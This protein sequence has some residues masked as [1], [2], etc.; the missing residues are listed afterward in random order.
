MAYIGEDEREAD[1][2][3]GVGEAVE[4]LIKLLKFA[5]LIN[6]PLQD[7]V[8]DTQEISLNGVRIMLGLGGKGEAASHELAE[9][10]AMHPMNVSRATAELRRE[11]RVEERCDPANRRRKPLH[12]TSAGWRSYERLI[13]QIRSVAEQLFA[14]V[15][16][17]EQR[18]LSCMID[19][20]NGEIEAT[21]H[22]AA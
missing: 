9:L 3:P 15:T 11:G 21:V 16:H 1:A 22:S 13:P 19:R 18:L 8:A 5:N 7:Q 2:R 12:L 20:I 14:R 17:E 4:L 10:M 6:R